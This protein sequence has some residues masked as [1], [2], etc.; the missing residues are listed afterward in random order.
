MRINSNLSR[1]R[2]CSSKLAMRGTNHTDFAAARVH[3][4]FFVVVVSA[5]LF[6]VLFAAGAV[7]GAV[8]G[9]GRFRARFGS[10]VAALALALVGNL[11]LHIND[12]A[13]CGR[14]RR[15]CVT[16]VS[17]RRNVLEH[18]GS[19]TKILRTTAGK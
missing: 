6:V 18:I 5:M 14:R 1:N 2:G 9:V 17:V 10:N 11:G 16:R 7:L 3:L 8:V 4:L 15:R 12:F 13:G 19:K